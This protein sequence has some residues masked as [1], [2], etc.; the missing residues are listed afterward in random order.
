MSHEVFETSATAS[1]SGFYTPSARKYRV[2]R[3]PSLAFMYPDPKMVRAT[4][5]KRKNHSRKRMQLMKYEDGSV[6]ISLAENVALSELLDL[7]GDSQSRT[8]TNAVRPP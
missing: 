1:N 7:S 5:F 3:V 4:E 8:V 6:E 2:S